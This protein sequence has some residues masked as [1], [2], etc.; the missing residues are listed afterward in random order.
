MKIIVGL[1]NPGEKYANNRHNV[2]CQF[3]DYLINELTDIELKKIRPTKTNVFVNQSGIAVKQLVTRFKL[4]VSRD[5]VVAHDDLD[6]PLGE[7]KIQKG[8][9]PRLH[10]GVNSIEKALGKKDFVRVRIGVENRAPENRVSGEAYVLSDF[11]KDERKVL[12]ERVFPQL[13]EKLKIIT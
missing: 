13:Y 5:L 12:N 2:G 10:N 7:C 1:G 6:I 3:I 9:G 4:Y 8:V 11:R